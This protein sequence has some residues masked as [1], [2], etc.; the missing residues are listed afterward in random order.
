[1]RGM[2]SIRSM[3]LV[4]F[5]LRKKI[6]VFFTAMLV[7]TV[8]V[9]LVG[10]I[11]SQR[12]IEKLQR[13]IQAGEEEVLPAIQQ[14][15]RINMAI[16]PPN[17]YLG[18]GDPGQV[19]RFD[20]L[21]TEVDRGFEEI[22]RVSSNDPMEKRLIQEAIGFWVVARHEAMSLSGIHQPAG[23]PEAV[24]HMALMDFYAGRAAKSLGEVFIL[25][26]S[27]RKK[28]LADANR[29]NDR[30]KLGMILI[31]VGGLGAGA[32]SVF[33]LNRNVMVPLR[34]LSEGARCL[35]EGNLD[36]H[37]EIS[38]GDELEDL[39]LEFNRMATSLRGSHA[40]LQHLA[41]HDGL[42]GLVNHREFYLR[43]N[44]EFSRSKRHGRPITLV[45]L[46]VDHFKKFNDLHGHPQGDLALKLIASA[47]KECARKSD[48]VA[49][50]GG[51]E[52]AVLLPE[53][54]LEEGLEL[55]LRVQ[56]KVS[57]SMPEMSRLMR[58][59]KIEVTLSIGMAA[60]PSE[61]STPEELVHVA[62]ERL[63]TAKNRGRNQICGPGRG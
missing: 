15:N 49:R 10:L 20:S 41:I 63:F 37:I 6:W 44:E 26:Q 12:V 2:G 60:F 58:K 39:A 34:S 43:L 48:L 32:G 62:D 16:M 53:T 18:T 47:I 46:D 45:M 21:A 7:P 33:F 35:A 28:D 38:T 30:M 31:L 40:A 1:M 5:S 25:S 8:L 24:K 19:L 9:A 27:E 3:D 59:D 23:N 56:K 52:F 55:G 54:S 4:R 11:L 17:D 22:A 57:E 42:T 14:Q 51:E 36:H 50:Y 61:A 29:S 13:S